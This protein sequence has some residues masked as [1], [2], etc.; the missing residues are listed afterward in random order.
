[1]ARSV[2]GLD[3]EH[4]SHTHTDVRMHASRG[5]PAARMVGEQP[6]G[7]AGS[8]GTRLRQ[9]GHKAPAPHGSSAPGGLHSRRCC[10]LLLPHQVPAG[11]RGWAARWPAGSPPPAARQAT[12]AAGGGAGGGG[13]FHCSNWRRRCAAS[14]RRRHTVCSCHQMVLPE[15]HLEWDP[16]AAL[17]SKPCAPQD[18][19]AGAGPVAGAQLAAGQVHL[20]RA[21]AHPHARLLACGSR[22]SKRGRV[23]DKQRADTYRTGACDSCGLGLPLR[24]NLEVVVTCT[25]PREIAPVS[26]AQLGRHPAGAVAAAASTV[27][28]AAVALLQRGFLLPPAPL[29]LILPLPAGLWENSTE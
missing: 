16:L 2:P 19:V 5:R 7:H 1:M 6:G 15:P 24:M 27:A 21:A 13:A 14:R 23:S 17:L 26:A 4:E 8:Q 28:A 18:P 9:T 25:L 12:P 20:E 22:N 29:Q 11:G 10:P 3:E